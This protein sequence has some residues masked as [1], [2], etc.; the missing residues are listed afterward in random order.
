[1]VWTDLRCGCSSL[2]TAEPAKIDFPAVVGEAI[3]GAPTRKVLFLYALTAAGAFHVAWSFS[4][5]NAFVL[6]YAWALI[7][8]SGAK[9][10]SQSFRFGFFAGFLVFAPQLTW[11]WK[12]FGPMAICLWAVLSFFTGVFAA[13]LH[14]ARNKFGD[15]FLWIIAPVLWTGIEF[16]RSELYALRFSWFSV[17]YDFSGSGGLVPVGFLGVYGVGFLVFLIAAVCVGMTHLIKAV[18][19]LAFIV[20]ANWPGKIGAETGTE[21]VVAG[22]Q[23]EFPPDLEIPKHLDRVI[24]RYPGAQILVL[25]EYAFDGSVPKHVREWCRRNERYLIAG[26]KENVIEDGRNDFRNTAFVVGPTGEIVFAQCKS[27]PIQFF[28]D[29]LPARAQR[30]WESPWGKIAIPICYDLSYR[31][32]TDRFAAGGAEAFIVPFMDVTDWG[33]RQHRQHARIAPIRARE[34][35]VPVFRLGSSGIS[36]HVDAHGRVLAESH[37]PGEEEIFGGTLKLNGKARLPLDHWIAP[38]CSGLVAFGIT[39]L[40]LNFLLQNSRTKAA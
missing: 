8:L 5:L 37:F 16:F 39:A 36:Q 21:L 19:L 4:V 34:Y 17:G 12:I 32:V 24:A 35:G 29:G 2:E 11:F 31:R 40:L 26:G 3:N 20:C 1:M 7:K 13:L 9:S 6:V 33:E 27:V 23:L 18:V 28:N 25:S 10:A 14:V 15:R 22:V 38:I 30:V